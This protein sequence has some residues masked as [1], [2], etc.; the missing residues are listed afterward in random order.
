[1]ATELGV[2]A[3]A[4]GQLIRRRRGWPGPPPLRQMI[5]AGSKAS[6]ASADAKGRRSKPPSTVCSAS[7]QAATHPIARRSLMRIPRVTRDIPQ[8]LLA[9]PLPAAQLGMGD[10]RGP[11]AFTPLVFP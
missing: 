6:A 2:L 8:S 10:L 3:G 5:A 11:V 1:M 7:V 9:C 4:C